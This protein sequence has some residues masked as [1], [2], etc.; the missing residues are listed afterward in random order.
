MKGLLIKDFKLMKN[1]KN[2]F[3]IMAFIAVAM[4]FAEFESTFVVSY[5]TMIASMF[6]LSTI[7]YDEYDNGYAFLFSLPFSRTSYVKEKYVF[8]ILMGGCAWLF[9]VALSGILITVRNPQMGIMDWLPA[10]LLYICLILLFASVMIPVQL[11]YGGERGRVALLLAVG[12][13]VL[14]SMGLIKLIELMDVDLDALLTSIYALSIMQIAGAIVL[15]SV[16]SLV[17]S[18][19]ISCRIMK[20]KQF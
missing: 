7:S 1:Q 5:F 11:K 15:F 4:M 19:R 10:N 17:I 3:F 14:G 8:S 9:S 16:V 2:F 6:V 12:V 20:H 18:Y 13:A